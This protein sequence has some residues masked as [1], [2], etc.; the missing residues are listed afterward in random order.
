LFLLQKVYIIWTYFIYNYICLYIFIY[1][2]VWKIFSR[3]VEITEQQKIELQKYSNGLQ[4]L[5][6]ALSDSAANNTCSLRFRHFVPLPRRDKH[7]R[8]ILSADPMVHYPQWMAEVFG[9][10][11]RA[12]EMLGIATRPSRAIGS[13]TRIN[14]PRQSRFG[15]VS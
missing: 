13:D 1:I 6:I 8:K 11:H 9:R 7:W 12:T 5:K 10:R 14:C 2:L 15:R 3:L 4:A